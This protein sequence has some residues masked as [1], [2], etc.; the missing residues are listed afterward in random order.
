MTKLTRVQLKL[1]DSGSILYKDSEDDVIFHIEAGTDQDEESTK[2]L[3]KSF[4]RQHLL[5]NGEPCHDITPLMKTESIGPLLIAVVRL[6]IRDYASESTT[7]V[8]AMYKT[9]GGLVSLL[10]Q[11]EKALKVAAEMM[12]KS[13]AKNDDSLDPEN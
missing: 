11:R 12:A 1:R 2:Q 8:S 5:K 10:Q 13:D 7:A 4:L 3:I 6:Q 9:L